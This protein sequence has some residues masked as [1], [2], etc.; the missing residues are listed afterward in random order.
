MSRITFR[1]GGEV[2]QLPGRSHR[3]KLKK[4]FQTWDIPP[5]ERNF[6]PILEVNQD[7]VAVGSQYV[8]DNYVAE[9]GEKGFRIKW[10]SN[11]YIRVES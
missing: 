6:V 5:W 4:L 1:K 11:L 2:C 9:G 10:D 7:I 8:N 3:H